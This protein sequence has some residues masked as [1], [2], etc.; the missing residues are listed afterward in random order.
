MGENEKNSGANKKGLEEFVDRIREARK[1]DKMEIPSKNK[2]RFQGL[3]FNGKSSSGKPWVTERNS[4]EG[5]MEKAIK[6]KTITT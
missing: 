6:K 2:K 3:S 4:H 1:N 5:S